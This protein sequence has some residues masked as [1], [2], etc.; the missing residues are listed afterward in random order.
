MA[1]AINTQNYQFSQAEKAFIAQHG[2]LGV[3]LLKEYELEHAKEAIEDYY[4]G[5]Y[6]NEE[7]FVKHFMQD[8][9]DEMLPI[10]SFEHACLS[11]WLDWDHITWQVMMDFTAIEA[12]DKTHIFHAF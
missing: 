8:R 2:E 11:R 9:A 4:Y 5:E 10:D 6:D 1:D 7:E 12:N 3:G